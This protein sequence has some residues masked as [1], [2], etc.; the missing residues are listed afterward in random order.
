MSGCSPAQPQADGDRR[1]WRPPVLAAAMWLGAWAGTSG[2]GWLLACCLVSGAAAGWLGWW[3]GRWLVVAAGLVLVAAV[4]IGLLRVWF[5]GVGP[6]PAWAR[7]GA[8]VVVEVRL[9]GGHTSDASRGGPVWTTSATLVR[10]EGRG[11]AWTS[12]TTVRLSA[13]GELARAWEA[14]ATGST[15]RTAVRLSP[16]TAD[17]P[18]A[19][20]AHARASPQLIAAP[21][22]GDAAVSAV[23]QG[24]RAAVAGL[25]PGPRALVPAL[26]V[27]DTELMTADL[28]ADFRTTGLI[29]LAAVSGA[30][31]TLLLAAMLWVAARLGVTGWWRRGVAAVGV[32]AF[33]LLCRAEPSVL[34]AA[35]MGVVGLA[36]L[37]WGG[38]R[39]GLR[40]LSWAVVGL[41]LLDPWLG[42]SVGFVLSVCASGGIILW[43]DRWAS[44]LDWAPR[45]LAEAVTVP[46]AAQL[47]TQP[48]VTAISG[49]VSLV[50][51]VANL[52]A[53]PLVGPGTVLGFLAAGLSV[54]WL[55]LASV[56]GWA[57]GGFAQALCWI[58]SAGASLPGAA[59]AWPAGPA[60]L[61]V[62]TACCG[63]ALVGLPQLLRRPWLVA[64]VL[65]AMV[66]VLLRPVSAPGWPPDGWQ[67]VSCDVGQ[68]DATVA[69]AGDG[70]AIVVDTGPDPESVD[71]CL[72]E[73]GVTEVAWLVLTH[74]HSDH[75]GGIAGVVSGRRVDNLLFSGITE[76]DP[77][78][79]LVQ[80]A[81]PAVPRTVAV[82]G[83]VVAAG[84]VRLAVLAVRPSRATTPGDTADTA[85]NSE[86]ND[87]SI[88]V[89]VTS[90]ELRVVLAGDVEEAGQENAVSAA[91]DLSAEVLL[92]PHHGSAH[93]SEGFLAAVHESVALV[94]VGANNDYGHPAAR[95]IA[96]V[97][98]LG[99][100]V[101]RTDQSGSIAVTRRGGELL[102]T[103]ERTG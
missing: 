71:R 77:G 76:P 73:L 30:N 7:E 59:M 58:A 3:R 32:V 33:V 92:V 66:A 96:S 57:A 93:Q 80:A 94:S 9:G 1:D 85:D 103:T 10:V 28:Q 49:Q 42:R 72:D 36:A 68:G 97:Q 24:L 70:R 39:Q 26:V 101:Y 78:W 2:N 17:E 99:A 22:P 34:R 100:R 19:A 16:A 46:I 40:Y 56:V 79:R 60:A 25:P 67:V 47:A 5:V 61:G 14:V 65:A 102:V 15:V 82:P 51:V 31:L 64:A 83:V 75:V 87:S 54:A 88:V 98:G 63:A 12:G 52:V 95:T 62:L 38:G 8:V 45:W 18:V 43:A 81:L 6:V 84:P 13:S 74:L 29:H 23:R 86:A 89:R 11:E 4:G 91:P 53:A 41:L 48:V 69:A 90:G 27:G 44:L 35:A 37:G 20:W 50:G 55:P 21:P